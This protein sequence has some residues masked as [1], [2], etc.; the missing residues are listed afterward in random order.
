MNN[1]TLH[2]FDNVKHIET[3]CVN[4]NVIINNPIHISYSGKNILEIGEPV[5]KIGD[6][7]NACVYQIIESKICNKPFLLF[8]LVNNNNILTF[9]TIKY[10]GK[11]PSVTMLN[12][13]YNTI[14]NAKITYNGFVYENNL[15]TLSYCLE[16]T[17]SYYVSK[18][19]YNSNSWFVLVNEIM[20]WNKLLNFYI[21]RNVISFFLNN[22]HMMYL[23]SN[24]G[25]I[26]E[27]PIV[28]YHGDSITKINLDIITGRTRNLYNSAF[29]PY[30]YFGNYANAMRYAIWNNVSQC[31]N[32]RGGIVRYA[33]FLG[34][35]TM[36]L[37]RKCDNI[38]ESEISNSSTSLIQKHFCKFR[39]SCGKWADSY[40]SILT[41]ERIISISDAHTIIR[42]QYILKNYEQHFILSYHSV[43]TNQNVTKNTSDNA[44]IE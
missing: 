39:D 21:D 14:K 6:K 35:H 37:G 8:L 20:N 41:P 16:F 5:L 3:S 10:Q 31:K 2:N 33:I 15:V 24:T 36:L 44:I 4:R 28:G 7:I 30:Y 40:D 13:L 22:P 17:E 23:I 18:I 38:I 1:I 12:M 27:T 29:G 43:N 19:S 32:M 26:L 34:K 9:P 42:S 11:K 25:T